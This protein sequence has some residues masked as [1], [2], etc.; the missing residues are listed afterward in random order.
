[1]GREGGSSEEGEEGGGLFFDLHGGSL[2]LMGRR[3]FPTKT[4]RGKGAWEV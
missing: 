4:R 1:L 2:G 3:K